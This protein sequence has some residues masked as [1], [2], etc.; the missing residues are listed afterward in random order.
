MTNKA[1]AIP[2]TPDEAPVAPVETPMI[3]RDTLFTSRVLI[4]PEGRTL[5]VAKRQVSVSPMDTV[6]LTYLQGRADFVALAG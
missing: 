4:L 2:D 6:A 5:R 3:F 1:K